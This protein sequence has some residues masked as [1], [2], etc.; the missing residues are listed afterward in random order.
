MRSPAEFAFR[1]RQEAAN[2]MLLASPPVF[3]GQVPPRLALP[4][5]APVV[6]TLQ[7]SEFAA[8]ALATAA[9]LLEHRFPLFGTTIETGSEIRWRRD[10][11]HGKES[12][13]AYFRRIPYLNFSEIGSHKF[14]WELNRHQHLVLLAQAFLFSRNREFIEEIFRQIESWL[15]Q[16][17]FPC[18][19]NWTSAL[20]VAFR[21]LSWIWIFHWIAPEMPDAFRSRFL[22]CLYRHG[23][24][25]AENLSIYFSPNTHLLG[26][27]VA[28]HALGA[29]FEAFPESAA[30]QR[31]GAEIVEAQLKFQVQPD[32]AHFEQSTYYHVYALDLFLL[33]YLLSGRPAAMEPVLVRMAEYLHWLLGP[34]GRISFFGDDDG[35]RVFHPYGERSEFGRATLATCGVLFGHPE[36]IGRETAEQL[37]WWLGAEALRSNSGTYS[38]V[39][40]S[41]LFPDS[42]S[43]FLQSGNLWV[44]ADAGPFGFGSAGHSHSDTLSLVAW[45][46]GEQ[47]LIDPGTYSYIANP[48]ERAW[49]RGSGAH[50]TVRMD[51]RDQ[52]RQ[53]GPF[54]WASKPEVSV[55]RWTAD[56]CRTRLDAICRYNGFTHRRRILLEAGRLLVADDIEGPPGEHICEQ[57]W[58][59]GPAACKTKLG[60]SA[61]SAVSKS[62]FSP[63]YG[64]QCPGTVITA[65]VSGLL[66]V[67]LAMLLETGEAPPIDIEEALRSLR[68]ASAD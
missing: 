36:W 63:V 64:T 27:A 25:L 18:G 5:P 17:P 52:A 10:Y 19:I 3:R 35:G 46:N 49:F 30:W 29:L 8:F 34:S 48:E 4:D 61:P 37:A 50:N 62:K 53:V 41:R 44:Q 31:R 12:S 58:H 65:L 28:L 54:R 24:Y 11:V 1:A 14:V 16:N 6:E 67:R 9:Q 39:S 66:P 15:D 42:G 47:V 21:S 33:H 57:I 38:P 7:Q 32:G 43:A 60:F 51:K 13:I 40:G 59:L 26:E 2:L 56:S 68:A 23:R 22:T 20:E 45:L 55:E